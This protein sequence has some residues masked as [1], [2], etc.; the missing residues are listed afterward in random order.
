[1]VGVVSRKDLLR[2]LLNQ[3]DQTLPVAIIMTRM[4]NIVRVT[5]EQTILE[6]ADL[7]I[8][9]QVDSLPVVVAAD[10]HQVVGKLTK[11]LLIEHFVSEGQKAK[12]ECD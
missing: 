7:L 9:S 3:G 10:S 12:G 5:P 4:P 6:A 1:M 11:T 2:S 8:K